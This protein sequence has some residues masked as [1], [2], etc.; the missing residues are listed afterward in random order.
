MDK[1]ALVGTGVKPGT[2]SRVQT[3]VESGF[4]RMFQTAL[5]GCLLWA[6]G[7]LAL[8]LGGLWLQ[9]GSELQ[10]AQWATSLLLVALLCSAASF[11]QRLLRWYTL[12][13]RVAPD[14]D[15][16]SGVLFGS[17]GFALTITPGRA[18]EALKLYLL[19]RRCGVPLATSAPILLVEKVTE[20]LGFVVLA[21]LGGLL[22][23]QSLIQD[24][25][26]A[27]IWATSDGA[28]ASTWQVAG[29]S[30]GALALGLTL[31]LLMVGRASVA[32]LAGRAL[33]AFVSRSA[34]LRQLAQGSSQLLATRPVV[35]ALA[36]SVGARLC[37]TA[38]LYWAARALGLEL[39]P[40]EAMVVLGSAGLI[41]GLS[42][43]PGGVG[44]VEA[45][46]AGVLVGLGHD[47]PSSLG[48]V[49]IAR[50]LILWLWVALGLG[51]AVWHGLIHVPA[52]PASS[53]AG[54]R[55]VE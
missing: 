54:E 8:G 36:L 12:A 26:V 4:G 51:L 14:L 25:A 1:D 3:A 46:M 41:G 39:S 40:A 42:L 28:Q 32:R 45:T 21:A 43:L 37:D 48:L 6:G 23:S 7:S 15:L 34:P 31:F 16:N 22:L 5:I 13:S 29:A 20:G 27:W 9:A 47:L 2:T 24:A 52:N 35:E 44:A 33:S 49:L 18:G 30:T 11:V 53:S 17:I 10:W 50:V 38:A 19:Q 55:G